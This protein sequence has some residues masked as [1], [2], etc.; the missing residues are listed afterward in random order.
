MAIAFEL[1][2]SILLYF[3]AGQGLLLAPQRRHRNI[4]MVK[5]AQKNIIMQ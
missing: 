5:T 3:T 4:L 1:S 2:A